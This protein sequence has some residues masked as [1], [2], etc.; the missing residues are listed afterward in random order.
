V[1]WIGLAQVRDKWSAL[2]NALMNIRGPLSDVF[3]VCQGTTSVSGLR[4]REL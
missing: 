1:D 3:G 2:V 4:D